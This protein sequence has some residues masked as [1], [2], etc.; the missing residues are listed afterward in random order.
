LPLLPEEHELLE[1][2]RGANAKQAAH[3]EQD[4]MKFLLVTF[5]TFF[6]LKTAELVRDA[7]FI[8]SVIRKTKR[9]F[10]TNN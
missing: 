4:D 2:A 5:V 9:S 10:D 6:F 1:I 3:A 8:I 7:L